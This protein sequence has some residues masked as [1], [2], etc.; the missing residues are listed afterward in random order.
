MVR[1]IYSLQ[2]KIH[3][4]IR[5]A[6]GK[7]GIP[8]FMVHHVNENAAENEKNLTIGTKEFRDFINVLI[9]NN[10]KFLRPEEIE[11][12]FGSK[13]CMVTFDDVCKD[14]IE[15]GIPFL[16]EKKIPYVCFVSPGFVDQEGYLN[17]N[18]LIILRNSGLCTIGAHSLHHKIFRNLAEQEKQEELAKSE[19]EILLDCQIKDFAFPYGSVYACDRASIKLAKK[20]YTRVYS[21]LNCNM[22]ENDLTRLF[23]RINLNSQCILNNELR[24]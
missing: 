2:Q 1:K 17:S 22:C 15:N 5:N 4:F 12:S 6:G 21:T 11:R 8:I 18:D 13:S 10:Y 9:D 7:D 14:A 19:H 24:L 3:E 20:E 16:E 23:P